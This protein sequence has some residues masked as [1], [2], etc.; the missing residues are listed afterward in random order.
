MSNGIDLDVRSQLLVREL[1]TPNQGLF[2][3]AF[4]DDGIALR[5]RGLIQEEIKEA[6][7]PKPKAVGMVEQ[8]RAALNLLEREYPEVYQQCKEVRMHMDDWDKWV[9]QSCPAS[10]RVWHKHKEWRIVNYKQV[11]RG[12]LRFVVEKAT[13]LVELPLGGL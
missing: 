4:Y 5:L 1:R 8:V 7:K 11:H 12:Q 3:P 2:N 6:A 10:D 13:E 9:D